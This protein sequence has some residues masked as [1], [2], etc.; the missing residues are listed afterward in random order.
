MVFA[1]LLDT[2]A[3]VFDLIAGLRLLSDNSIQP[4]PQKETRISWL[5]IG[6]HERHHP[7][8]PL[9]SPSNPPTKTFRSQKV[10]GSLYRAPIIGEA[11]NTHPRSNDRQTSR[12]VIWVGSEG[13]TLTC[14][15]M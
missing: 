14:H 9:G 3:I 5:A 15:G 1:V 4:R 10:V 13:R 8:C 6:S 11:R 2:S 12:T 7:T